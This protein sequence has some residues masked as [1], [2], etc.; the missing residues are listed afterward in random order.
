MGQEAAMAAPTLFE[1][2]GPRSQVAS[3]DWLAVDDLGSDDL[4]WVRITGGTSGHRADD[5][6]STLE[7][8]LQDAAG[9]MVVVDLARVTGFDVGTVKTLVSVARAVKRWHVDMCAVANPSSAMNDYLRAHSLDH[10]IP[11]YSSDGPVRPAGSQV[12]VARTPRAGCRLDQL[13]GFEGF[14]AHQ[15]VLRVVL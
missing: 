9:R 8:A 2:T 11:L 14:F 4:V 13:A 15:Y 12:P 10:L 6:W 3:S 5:L 7:M 1:E